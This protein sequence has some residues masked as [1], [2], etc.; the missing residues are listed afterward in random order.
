M[1]GD[2]ESQ[3]LPAFASE[4]CY[5]MDLQQGIGIDRYR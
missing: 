5:A 3:G 2:F 1:I 4:S